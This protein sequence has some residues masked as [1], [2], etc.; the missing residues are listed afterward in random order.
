MNFSNFESKA[1]FSIILENY[2]ILNKHYSNIVNLLN[3]RIEFYSKCFK[4]R[5]NMDSVH[6]F[7]VKSYNLLK[8]LWS[9]SNS[10]GGLKISNLS[11]FL[12][13]Q[14]IPQSQFIIAG[15]YLMTLKQS[16]KEKTIN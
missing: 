12:T 2:L 5:S 6:C 14:N 1:I 11:A 4:S 13:I 15:P 9:V 8:S 7:C 16:A 10:T 3:E